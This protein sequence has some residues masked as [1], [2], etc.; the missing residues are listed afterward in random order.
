MSEGTV[1]QHRVRFLMEY[2]VKSNT[3]SILN[4]GRFKFRFKTLLKT[5]NTRSYVRRK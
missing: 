4:T 5:V 1:R 3:R 2:S